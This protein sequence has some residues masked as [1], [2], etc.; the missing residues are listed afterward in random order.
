MQF[1]PDL[2]ASYRSTR[3]ARAL[4][5]GWLALLLGIATV[6]ARAEEVTLPFRGLTLNANL[7]LAP[8]KSL[9]D[10]VVLVVHGGLA[11]NRMEF[12]VYLQSLLGQNGY[13]TLAIN[14]SLGLDDRRGM[15]DCKR[16]HRH[17]NDD[18]LDEIGAW[19]DW[20]KDKGA[21][22][23]VLLGH[24]RGGSQAALYAT[25][26]DHPLL[27]SVV[28]M[29]PATRDNTDLG[30]E[31]RYKQPLAPIMAR[32]EQL[33]KAGKGDTLLEHANVMT[34]SDTQVSASS[35][36]SYF[37]ATPRL[38]SP[39]LIPKI[40]VPVLV[41]VAG[42]DEAVVGLEKKLA[43]RID[44]V[45]AKMKVIDGADHFFRDLYSDDAVDAIVGFLGRR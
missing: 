4:A 29:A 10:G 9:A 21:T 45:R 12:I 25:E 36:V 15:Y 31:R 40:K 41:L 2:P 8:G 17:R 5:G 23:V 39:E 30:Y 13:S 14:L 27:K 38:D 11:H 3:C 20:L 44:G 42:S 7:E 1:V 37:A 22:S 16:P 19:L 43:G 32:A 24:S 28:L 26:H 33:V 34:C 18:A 6:A 35:F